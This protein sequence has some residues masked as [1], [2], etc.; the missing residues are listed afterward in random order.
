MEDDR[1]ASRTDKTL[2]TAMINLAHSIDLKVVA[3]GVENE[4]QFAFLKQSGCDLFQG[5]LLGKPISAG[6]FTQLLE[7]QMK[8]TS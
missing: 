5:Y 4:S 6:A 7:Q 3:E 1:T 2:V 8:A